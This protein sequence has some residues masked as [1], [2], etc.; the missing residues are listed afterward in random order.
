M[1]SVLLG[2]LILG[3]VV[4]LIVWKFSN[5]KIAIFVGAVLSVAF[6]GLIVLALI[7]GGDH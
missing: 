1:I 7:L 3:A 2:C 5:L 4:G 6:F